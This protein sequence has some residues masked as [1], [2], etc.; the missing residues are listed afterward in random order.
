MSY[1]SRTIFIKPEETFGDANN[2]CLLGYFANLEF[3]TVTRWVCVLG[4]FYLPFAS[5]V[6]HGVRCRSNRDLEA[7]TLESVLGFAGVDVDR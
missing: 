5:T 1:I 3:L 7:G 4:H 2:P 6:H